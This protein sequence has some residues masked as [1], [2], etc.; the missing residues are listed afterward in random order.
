MYSF[1]VAINVKPEHQAAFVD[2]SIT[3]GQATV[4]EERGVFRYD[5][6]RDADNPNRFYFYEIFRDKEA[7]EAH[8]ETGHFKTWWSTVENMV[9]GE[10]DRISTMR[11][12]FPST[13]G[14][15]R[16][17]PSLLRW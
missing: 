15:E 9:D 8:W 14:L 16:Q 13:E 11:P 6:L 7:A 4:K 3:V 10:F 1:F 17:R 2:A 5:V 12:V